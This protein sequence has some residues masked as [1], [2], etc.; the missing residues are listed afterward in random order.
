MGTESEVSECGERV[1]LES[2]VR[3]RRERGKIGAKQ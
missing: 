2:S 3:V 1:G